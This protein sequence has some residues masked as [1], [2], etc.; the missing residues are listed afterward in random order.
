MTTKESAKRLR[1]LQE[2]QVHL[3][4]GH[5]RGKVNVLPLVLGHVLGKNHDVFVRVTNEWL[6]FV[7]EGKL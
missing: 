2:F 1:A 5:I 7:I 3:V 6:A 4:L